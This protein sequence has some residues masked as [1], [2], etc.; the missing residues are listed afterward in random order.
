MKH[1]LSMDDLSQDEIMALID[2]ALMIKQGDVTPFADRLYVSNLFFEN[3]T[4]TKKS[5]EMAQAKLGMHTIDFEVSTSSVNKGESLYDTCKT[6]EAIGCDA[7]VIRHPQN[8]YYK[9]LEGLN[10][11][12][13]N[14]GDG[15][16]SHPSQSLLDLLTIYERFGK[17]EGLKV[18][19]VGDILHS[20][21]AK[22]NFQ[23]LTKLG[24]QVKFVAPA[25]YQDHNIPVEYVEMDEVIDQV[26]VCM[27]LRVQLERHVYNHEDI[28]AEY[29]QKYGMNPERYARLKEDAIIMHPAPINRGVEI[30]S[31][32]VEADKS[33]I[34]QQMTNGVY[35]RM[36]ILQTVL[37]N[38][39]LPTV[40]MH[41]IAG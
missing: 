23:A 40:P 14:G 27:L 16:G 15:S 7:L 34:F 1:L 32:L 5:F 21:V 20:R 35:M 13:I 19:I 8:E 33:V 37:E 25:E 17:F 38:H 28:Q 41:V 6:M 4:R 2:R 30:T 31:E 3:S 11:P 12:V 36:S 26:D 10:I 39:L 9:E 18:I 24:A 22:S 29:N